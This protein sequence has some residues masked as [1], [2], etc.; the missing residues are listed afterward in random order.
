VVEGGVNTLKNPAYDLDADAAVVD[1]ALNGDDFSV[2][3]ILDGVDYLHQTYPYAPIILIG[4]LPYA[5]CDSLTCPSL[6]RPIQRATLYNAA[7]L[8]ACAGRPWLMCTSPYSGFEG[9]TPGHLQTSLAC[10]DGIHLKVPGASLLASY[11]W[12]VRLW[13]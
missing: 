10:E 8:S 4:V 9:S 12:A 2:L 7:M 13:R 3:G 6:V 1:Y 11:V 5:G